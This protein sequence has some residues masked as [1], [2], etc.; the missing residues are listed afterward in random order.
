MLALTV[1]LSR[2][3]CMRLPSNIRPDRSLVPIV[4]QALA[5]SPTIHRQCLAIA[6]IPSARVDIHLRSGH[7]AGGARAEARIVRYEFGAI[8]AEI[9]IP[10]CVDQIEMLAHELEHV[11]E[12]I[13]GVNLAKQSETRGTGV[14]RLSDGT[15]ETARARAAG[16]AAAQEISCA[17]SPSRRSCPFPPS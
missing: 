10:V 4:E 7:M 5:Q 14:S 13:E 16:R 12:Q 17:T 8:S 2:P 9:L 3:D 1:L 15:F 11:L 6:A